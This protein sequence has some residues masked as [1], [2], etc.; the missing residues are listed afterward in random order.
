MGENIK[1][2][3]R[4]PKHALTLCAQHSHTRIHTHTRPG[5]AR[6]LLSG[7]MP[8]GPSSTCGPQTQSSSLSA[9]GV[10]SASVHCKQR[11]C[12]LSRLS[13]HR[14]G[15]PAGDAERK[16]AF[17]LRS[18]AK[19]AQSS[20]QASSR[21]VAT[22]SPP[23]DF[24]HGASAAILTAVNAAD[25]TLGTPDSELRTPGTGHWALGSSW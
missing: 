4:I 23:I 25:D 19:A 1:S 9:C 11:T 2:R 21:K 5:A 8:S 6:T 10:L 15:S 22:G 24:A 18:L 12:Q 7:E 3:R 13:W 14:P 20:R 17:S 16:L